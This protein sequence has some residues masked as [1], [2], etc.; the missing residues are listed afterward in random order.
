MAA[1]E[2][3][4]PDRDGAETIPDAGEA[5]QI[6]AEEYY[7]YLREQGDGQILDP[8]IHISAKRMSDD[9][10]LTYSQARYRIA[11]GVREGR[12][13][14]VGMFYDADVCRNVPC[15]VAVK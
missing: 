1:A 9:L 11:K 8:R 15:Y 7:D 6:S 4:D 3:R 2:L 10:G 13:V 12:L 14:R 5:D